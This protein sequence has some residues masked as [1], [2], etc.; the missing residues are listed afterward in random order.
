MAGDQANETTSDFKTSDVAPMEDEQV[1][2]RTNVTYINTGRS[3][4][5]KYRRKRKS[6]E[7]I[8][9][10]KRAKSL[11]TLKITNKL[12]AKKIGRMKKK[13]KS[14]SKKK[15]NKKPP[16]EKQLKQ[17]GEFADKVVAAKG[18]Y[19]AQ[20]VRS[21]EMWQKCMKEAAGKLNIVELTDD[22]IAQ[23]QVPPM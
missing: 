12:L 10:D 1:Q 19:Y 20:E 17:W 14:H 2:P 9:A 21:T 5:Q 11:S 23:L 22:Q 15:T 18:A 4:T 8:E 6:P 7:V 3:R 13:S 16:S